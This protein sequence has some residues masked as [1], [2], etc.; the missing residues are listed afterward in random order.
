MRLP[1][2]ALTA[3]VF[4]AVAGIAVAAAPPAL[5]HD[6][7]VS[8]TPA[9]GATL[10]SLPKSIVLHFE[11]PPAE[12]YTRVTV[13]DATGTSIDVT[14]TTDGSD[15]TATPVSHTSAPSAGDFTVAYSIMSDDGHPVSG[16]IGFHLV[17]GTNT[18]GASSAPKRDSS[19]NLGWVVLGV[20]VLALGGVFLSW[21][22][23]RARTSATR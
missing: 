1:R 8:S 23:A 18:P 16:T 12:G 20:A 21:R 5:A 22:T 2:L 9:A 17:P 11:E 15:V 4:A 6:E 14:V 13:H 19:Q 10:S 3:A 7:L